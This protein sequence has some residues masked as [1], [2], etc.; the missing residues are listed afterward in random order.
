MTS[1]FVTLF[2]CPFH[3]VVKVKTD[4]IFRQRSRHSEVLGGSEMI[5][6]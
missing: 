1:L 5:C 2:L 6:T 3:V 4:E